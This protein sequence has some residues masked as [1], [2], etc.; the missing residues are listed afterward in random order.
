MVTPLD[1]EP[2]DRL[3]YLIGQAVQ[4]DVAM[5]R[6]A[7]RV[8]A[9]LAGGADGLANFVVLPRLAAVVDE[10]TTMLGRSA[11][12]EPVKAAGAVAGS[13]CARGE[14]RERSPFLVRE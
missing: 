9:Q 10:S 7:R 11:L 6:W 5:E 8:G 13:S 1:L 4:A 3:T 14:Q 12:D 2:H